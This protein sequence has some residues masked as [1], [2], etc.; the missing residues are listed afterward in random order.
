MAKA[1]PSSLTTVVVVLAIAVAAFVLWRRVFSPSSRYDD[2]APTVE[3]PRRPVL[4]SVPNGTPL[5][6]ADSMRLSVDDSFPR[7]QTESVKTMHGDG[8]AKALVGDVAARLK[9]NGAK[10]TPLAVETAKISKFVDSKGV[11]QT[12]LEFLVHDA[13]A[14]KPGYPAD[15]VSK[16]AATYLQ[17]PGA[18]PS[19]FSL[20]FATPRAPIEGAPKG[21]DADDV[22][23]ARFVSPLEVFR[24]MDFNG[25]AQT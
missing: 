9:K 16:L 23:L 2:V 6:L 17:A 22:P 12:N 21:F 8:E 3:K 1:R 19:L 4:A 7:I 25:P 5:S 24:Q 11:S 18:K 20:T 14:S 13:T 15:Q 10:V